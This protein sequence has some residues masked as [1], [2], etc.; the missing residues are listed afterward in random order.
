ML[1]FIHIP[2]QPVTKL[3]FGHVLIPIPYRD[4]DTFPTLL[5]PLCRASKGIQLS[6]SAALRSTNTGSTSVILTPL[7][8]S[9]RPVSGR[10]AGATSIAQQAPITPGQ[11]GPP[12][13]PA[14]AAHPFAAE[15]SPGRPAGRTARHGGAGAGDARLV[16]SAAT[17]EPR[18]PAN[19]TARRSPTSDVHSRHGPA[20]HFRPTP[21][22]GSR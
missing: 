2:F 1:L 12:A 22:T 15:R 6:S 13:L 14:E 17:R 18:A 20:A 7:A 4:T 11:P 5:N 16:R 3:L 9:H 10:L 19:D 8:T 21:G